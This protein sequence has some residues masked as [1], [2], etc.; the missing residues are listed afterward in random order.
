M[1]E[2]RRA[3]S[4]REERKKQALLH[5][6]EPIST[7]KYGFF[8]YV[9][10]CCI[11]VLLGIH[12]PVTGGQSRVVSSFLILLCCLQARFLTGLEALHFFQAGWLENSLDLPIFVCQCWG[13]RHTQPSATFLYWCWGFELR[14]SHLH[15]M[16]SYILTHFPSAQSSLSRI[17]LHGSASSQWVPSPSHY[18]TE[19]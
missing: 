1:A 5:Y 9:C 11:N 18:H 10:V 17:L 19:E 7:R 6:S 15:Y 3:V 16:Q 8:L 4:Y 13:Y 2:R 14:Y 12:V